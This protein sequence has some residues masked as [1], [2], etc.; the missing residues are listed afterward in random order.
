MAFFAP[1]NAILNRT[2]SAVIHPAL[3]FVLTN[4]F[5]S[6]DAFKPEWICSKEQQA[7]KPASEEDEAAEERR[8]EDNRASR[9]EYR[10]YDNGE[11]EVGEE[12]TGTRLYQAP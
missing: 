7:I 9:S 6:H 2:I 3:A 10:L 12:S 4:L 5:P 8:S 1:I 11:A